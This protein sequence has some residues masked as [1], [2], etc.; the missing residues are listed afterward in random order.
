MD[1]RIRGLPASHF[2]HLFG[3]SDEA[4]SRHRA[5]RRVAD[6]RPFYPCRI[7]LTD[8]RPGDEII[9]VNYEH[10]PVDSPYRALYAIYVREGEQTYDEKNQVPEQ[11]RT[12]LLSLRAFDERAILTNCLVTT[13]AELEGAIERLFAK[14]SAKY[15]HAHY[16]EAGCYAARIERA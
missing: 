9:L 8:A 6:E 11:L 14:P 4:L 5:L 3:L 2:S 1:F 7:S 12:R 10:H 16:A 13:G 15:I